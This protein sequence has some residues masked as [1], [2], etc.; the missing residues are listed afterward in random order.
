MIRTIG[1]VLVCKKLSSVKDQHPTKLFEKKFSANQNSN[2]QI[3]SDEY[4]TCKAK[5]YMPR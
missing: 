1:T 2:V 5:R 4:V 3:V